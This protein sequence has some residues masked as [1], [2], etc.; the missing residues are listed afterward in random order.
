MLKIAL[1]DDNEMQQDILMDQVSDYVK[2]KG[3]EAEITLFSNGNELLDHVKEN[4]GFDIYVLD[5]IMPGMKGIDLGA[6]LRNMGDK[7]HIIYLTITNAF[8]SKAVEVQ[9]SI[10][11]LKPITK[12]Q[13]ANVLDNVITQI[14]E[15]KTG[16]GK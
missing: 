11:L 16:E 15:E 6:E 10:Y 4:G 12:S 7:G 2:E 13:L 3:I 9:A 5:M 8:I 14:D 1:C